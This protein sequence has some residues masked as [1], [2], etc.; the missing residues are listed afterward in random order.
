MKAFVSAEE[1]KAFKKFRNGTQTRIH[2]GPFV[3]TKSVSIEEWRKL[4]KEKKA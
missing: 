1:W 3:T 2:I 4:K